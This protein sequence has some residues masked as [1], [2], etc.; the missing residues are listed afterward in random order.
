[1]YPEARHLAGR[2]HVYPGCRIRPA[3]VPRTSEIR[4]NAPLRPYSRN[5]PYDPTV[6][7]GPT[8]PPQDPTVEICPSPIVV[9]G[10]GAISHERGTPVVQGS[11]FN[12]REWGLGV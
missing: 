9:L 3:G 11:G 4:N 7:I 12:G 8:V 10:G 2:H 5:R 6:G 1:M